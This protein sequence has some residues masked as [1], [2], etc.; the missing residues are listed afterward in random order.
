MN[1]INTNAFRQSVRDIQ[2]LLPTAIRAIGQDPTDYP[3]G[4]ASAGI[5]GEYYDIGD[6]YRI[7]SMPGKNGDDHGMLLLHGPEKEVWS[8]MD[9]GEAVV[10][11]AA[12]IAQEAATNAIWEFKKEQF[13][14]ALEDEDR[15]QRLC[16]R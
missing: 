8:G 16:P 3:V 14:D 6:D 13:T 4:P 5:R 2:T 7:E 15:Y 9:A 12:H 10:A 1:D 11:L